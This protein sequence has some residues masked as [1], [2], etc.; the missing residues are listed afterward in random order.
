MAQLTQQQKIAIR[1]NPLWGDELEIG[2]VYYLD[3]SLNQ[4]ARFDRIEDGM[5]LFIGMYNPSYSINP[6]FLISGDFYLKEE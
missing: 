5:V 1:K 6:K 4:W 3:R 2:K